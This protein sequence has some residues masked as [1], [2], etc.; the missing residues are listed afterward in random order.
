MSVTDQDTGQSQVQDVQSIPQAEP[1]E[2]PMPSSE[3]MSSTE[4]APQVESELPEDVSERTKQQFDKL[5]ESNRVLREQLEA[6]ERL[7]QYGQS[8]YDFPRQ[9][10]PAQQEVNDLDFVDQEGNVDIQGLN[11]ALKEAGE[12]A[13]RAEE[14]A[15]LSREEQ[16]KRQQAE[17]I[18]TAHAKHAWL[19]PQSPEFDPKGFELARDRMARLMME[20][21]SFTL[22]NV[23]DEISQIYKPTGANV[24]TARKAVD[25]YKKTQETKAQATSVGGS[26]QKRTD[27]EL[28]AL[29]EQSRSS[30]QRERLQAIRERIRKY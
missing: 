1:Q 16:L 2:E 13:R 20:G 19:D 9:Q 24:D 6:K 4:N 14:L 3:V 5:K 28:D 25:E 11:K 15:Q 18:R 26:N 7:S 8:V 30:D 21:K 22:V 10:Q 27:T 23:A 29:R 12:R 17:E